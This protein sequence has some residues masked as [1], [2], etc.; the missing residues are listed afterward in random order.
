MARYCARCGHEVQGEWFDRHPGAAVT[1]FVLLAIWSL[2]AFV[3]YPL[4]TLA[5]AAL[6]AGPYVGWRE[7]K[8]HKALQSRFDWEGREW[9]HDY[10]S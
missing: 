8:R 5:F 7:Y 9:G 1:A 4:G 3:A 10:Y 2:A 6:T